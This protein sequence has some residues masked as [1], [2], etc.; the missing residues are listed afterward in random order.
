MW[1]WHQQSYGTLQVM[2]YGRLIRFMQTCSNI[3]NVKLI[4]ESVFQK[5]N[6]GIL[7]SSNILQTLAVL[8]D[9]SFWHV[10]CS[11]N[12]SFDSFFKKIS[13]RQ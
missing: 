1:I 12:T 6:T 13:D 8:S 4:F 3:L 7:L 10:D 2:L 5:Q 9:T 11:T